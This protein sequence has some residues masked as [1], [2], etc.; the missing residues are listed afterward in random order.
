MTGTPLTKANSLPGNLLRRC[1]QISV[2]IFLRKCEAYNL[3]QLQYVLL[4]A[5]DEKGALD[6]IT[7]GGF[8]ALDRNTVAVVV[9]KLEERGLVTRRRNPEDR[10]S[11]L[12]TL[13]E[14]GERLRLDAESA[15]LAAQ[16]EILAPLSEP[17]RET[18]CRL[19]Q[20]L[21]DENNAL[22]RVPI[23]SAG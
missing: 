11:M 2:A 17:E 12:V 7:L 23:R 18:L 20:R 16:D 1:H 4:S 15:V 6:Q 10:R 19:L 9:R 5:L 8:T 21:A 22:S 13:T 3:T 14:E